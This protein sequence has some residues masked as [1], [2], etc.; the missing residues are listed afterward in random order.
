MHDFVSILQD[1]QLLATGFFEMVDH[2]SEG[3]MRQISVPASF[4]RTPPQPFRPAP[5]QGEHGEDILLEA[6]FSQQEIDDLLARHA[7]ITVDRADG[8]VTG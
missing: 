7:L 8:S 3:R 6:G 5:R 4:S 2:P 1:P